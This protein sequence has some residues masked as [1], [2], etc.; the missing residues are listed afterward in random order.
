MAKDV[1]NFKS[2][3]NLVLK[4]FVEHALPRLSISPAKIPTFVEQVTQNFSN[5]LKSCGILNVVIDFSVIGSE[6]REA[7]PLLACEDGNV[8]LMQIPLIISEKKWFFH[9]KVKSSDIAWMSTLL[10]IFL[11]SVHTTID[12]IGESEPQSVPG[13]PHHIVE[14]INKAAASSLPCLILGETG[15]G[16]EVVAEMIHQLS[17]RDGP[18]VAVNCG[19][20]PHGLFENEL[21]GHEPNSYT[22]SSKTGL[23]GKIEIASGGTLFLDE[24]G[25][26]SMYT[27]SKL[28]RVIEKGEFWKIG[29][30]KPTKVDVKFIAATNRPLKEYIKKG[31]FRK[32][33]YYRL[34]GT[35]IYIPP[36]RERVHHIQELAQH[37]LQ[38]FSKGRVYF[39]EEGMS[40][41]RAYQWPG[42]VRELKYF[43][44]SLVDEVKQGPV[45]VQ[46]IKSSLDLKTLVNNF[47]EARRNFE[48]QYISD[49]LELNRWNI[50]KTAQYLGMS[51]RWLQMKMKELG[52]RDSIEQG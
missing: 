27:Q 44:H 2:Y 31:K 43:I 35:E 45:A 6:V 19:A 20:I 30:V 24:I 37:F 52:L 34:K 39:T 21:F 25:E 17:G 38:S 23:K 36:L 48:R 51:R 42:N 5:L 46:K 13:I 40:L 50:T 18:F 32:D 10:L 12:S 47:E 8:T 7:G 1:L 33:L 49:A 3:S 41:L 11:F 28:L 9:L 15:V 16:K 29:A 4:F 22:G 26:M 14:K